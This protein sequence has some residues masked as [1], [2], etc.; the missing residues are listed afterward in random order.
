VIQQ[1]VG[2]DFSGDRDASQRVWVSQVTVLDGR[3]KLQLLAPV[4]KLT[5]LQ[6][7]SRV[8]TYEY[9]R[10]LLAGITH[11]MCG[12]DVPFSLPEPVVANGNWYQLL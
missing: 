2:V 3:L 5:G 9:L 1:V 7:T 4:A 8:A 10:K 6:Q 11:S 12:L